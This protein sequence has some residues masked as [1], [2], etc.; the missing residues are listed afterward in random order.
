MAVEDIIIKLDVE[1]GDSNAILNALGVNINKFNK[2]IKENITLLGKNFAVTK[3]QLNAN[4]SFEQGLRSLTNNSRRFKME[5]LSVMF[6]GM[7][8]QRM[9]GGIVGKQMQLF[10]ISDM[11]SSMWTMVMLPVME[12]I[13]PI[14]YKIMEWFMNLP[15]ETKLW[16]GRLIIAA[17]IFGTILAVVGSVA[18]AVQGI[19]KVIGDLIPVD[20][21]S[22]VSIFGFSLGNI[23]GS[24]KNMATTGGV[25]AGIIALFTTT[26]K[27]VTAASD[28]TGESQESLFSGISGT[29]SKV[30]DWVKGVGSTV[31]DTGGKMFSSIKDIWGSIKETIG[32]ALIWIKDK[33]V[34]VF[35]TTWSKLKDLLPTWMT[36]AIDNGWQSIL[37]FIQD[38]KQADSLG[39]AFLAVVK[40]IKTWGQI[41]VFIAEKMVESI[42]ENLPKMIAAGLKG[43]GKLSLKL[44]IL[45]TIGIPLSMPSFQTGGLVTQTGPA[46]LHRGEK[47]VPK[48]RT[49]T[50]G[51][52]VFSPT[53]YITSTINN[54]MDIRQLATKLNKYWAEDF[55][56][57]SR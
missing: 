16:I 20:A 31:L 47:V 56:R 33:I 8:L 11:L 39:Q 17:A 9:F 49:E 51:E 50:S 46:L 21:L 35:K 25:L 27:G 26:L 6:A 37:D 14:L 2:H 48:G 41:G 32:D 1:E 52:I 28:E 18:L 23:I 38:L 36:D 54:D 29:L 53:V 13:A 15:D 55:Q 5:W 30:V 43:L 3:K 40:L 10:G 45:G 4:V 19:S 22:N 42:V 12:T 7:A 34:S 57:I 24:F 44:G